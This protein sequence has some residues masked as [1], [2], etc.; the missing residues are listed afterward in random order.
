[1]LLFFVPEAKM[2]TSFQFDPS[3]GKEYVIIY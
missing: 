1:L 3:L 2:N